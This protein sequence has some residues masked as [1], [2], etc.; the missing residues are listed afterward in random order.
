MSADR[1]GS[2]KCGSGAASDDPPADKANQAAYSS[3]AF[4]DRRVFELLTPPQWNLIVGILR[5]SQREQ[6]IV[7]ALLEGQKER[8]IAH[9]LNMSPHT[10]RTHLKRM[11]RKLQVN[12]RTE[13]VTTIF[14]AYVEQFGPRDK[15]TDVP[16]EGDT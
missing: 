1:P 3:R 6:E 14:L 13:L 16:A 12:D 2:E 9:A 4:S 5:L 15:T 8:S 7:T 10:V 11:Y